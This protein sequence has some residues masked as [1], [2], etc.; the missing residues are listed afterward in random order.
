MNTQLVESIVQLIKSLTPEEPALI[1]AKLPSQE[2]GK[3]EY[4]KLLQLKR[5]VSER[6]NNKPFDPPIE[7]YLYIT[8]EERNAQQD[9]LIAELFGE[10]SVI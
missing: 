10:K 6:R 2:D 8:R 5:K 4:Q 1:E 3:T 7:D 9:E